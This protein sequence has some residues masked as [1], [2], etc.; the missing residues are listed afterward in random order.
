MVKFY[1]EIP[2]SHIAW[3]KKQHIFFVAT[4]PMT[5]EHINVSPKGMDGTLH[6]ES[7][8][9][10][11]YED[12]SGSGVETISHLRENGRITIMF[13]AYEGPAR[14][15]RIYGR[16][17]VHEFGTPEYDALIPAVQRR[18]G[19]RAAIVIDVRKV[20]TS[21]GYAVPMYTFKAER[22][23][24][25]HYSV[26]METLDSAFPPRFLPSADA[27]IDAEGGAPVPT[28]TLDTEAG[29]RV[30]AK[31]GLK[32]WWTGWN[33]RSLDGLPALRSAYLSDAPL[34]A[35]GEVRGEAEPPSDGSVV[36]LGNKVP[37]ARSAV[38]ERLEAGKVLLPGGA[39]EMDVAI[40]LIEIGRVM[41]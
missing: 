6:I 30:Y 19:S 27:D 41:P 31:G 21:C 24:L 17:T 11:W 40:T 7:P 34:G 33:V 12:L 13:C 39:G 3:I 37:K 10:V 38:V 16:G 29:P 26:K 25:A 22:S 5:G 15:L 4:A 2:Q 1:D 32:A 14:I 23:A 8:T 9:R 18:P 35:G 36:I 28:V 20:S